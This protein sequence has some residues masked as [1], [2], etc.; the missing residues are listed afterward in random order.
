MRSLPFLILLGFVWALYPDKPGHP[1]GPD[2]KIS[3]SKC[4]SSK[5]WMLDKEIY[6]FDHGTTSLPLSGSHK[7]LNCRKC[8]TSLIFSEAGNQCSDCHNDV[9]QSSVG[10]NC[11]RCH[12]S[13]SW[14]V[15]DIT[16]IHQRSR[17]P[18]LGAHKTAEC[19][20]C[21]KAEN[22]VRFEVQGIECIDCHLADYQATANPNH[23]LAG[24]SMDCSKCHLVNAYQWDGAGFNHNFFP[25]AQGHSALNCNACHTTGSYA[26][27]S[28]DCIS[29]HQDDFLATTNPS[30]TLTGFPVTCQVCHTLAAGWKPASFTQHDGLYF[31]V[32]SGRH[33]GTWTSCTEC[34][35]NP[36]NFAAY[37]CISC[38]VHNKTDMD[39]KHS[40]ETGYSYTSAACLGCHPAGR[41]EKK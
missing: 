32:Y 20:A 16:D 31:P 41:A 15:K 34:H 8:H 29:C 22:P 30:H 18:L 5:G 24:F 37:T 40:G 21:H 3:C 27:V 2:F 28:P 36:A 10:F 11:E 39:N 4:H 26:D 35:P 17:F 19:A 9:H 1:H 23:A 7:D 33:K 38:H 13:I 12:T 6:S 14:L 25:L